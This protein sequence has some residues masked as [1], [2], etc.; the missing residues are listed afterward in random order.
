MRIC[1]TVALFL[2]KEVKIWTLTPADACCTG[3]QI[4]H[5]FFLFQFKVLSCDGPLKS[6]LYNTVKQLLS[7]ASIFQNTVLVSRPMRGPGWTSAASDWPMELSG[8]YLPSQDL[9]G[10]LDWTGPPGCPPV[11]YNM[12]SSEVSFHLQTPTPSMAM[13]MMT[14]NMQ[15][16]EVLGYSEEIVGSEDMMEGQLDLPVECVQVLRHP[17]PKI[18]PIAF[19]ETIVTDSSFH[20]GDQ[21]IYG[22][23]LIVTSEDVPQSEE[24]VGGGP[25]SDPYVGLYESVPIPNIDSGNKFGVNS[26]VGS[27]KQK[28]SGSKVKRE[29]DLESLSEGRLKNSASWQ[30]KQVSIKTLEGE[31]SVT[32]WASGADDGK[33]L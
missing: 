2:A 31:F 7:P 19:Q 16:S 10:E 17:L 29:F 23:E 1:H 8:C 12:A 6:L 22:D 21:I 30:Q 15:V 11:L 27:K 4:F 25:D 28:N 5:P 13:T 3:W 33:W 18:K 20:L 14:M 24:I 32:M 9:F 26:F